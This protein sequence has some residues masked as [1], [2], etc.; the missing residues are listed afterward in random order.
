MTLTFFL[1]T[2]EQID[3]LE[4]IR[5]ALNY[6]DA[7]I[8]L[9]KTLQ[10]VRASLV[11]LKNTIDSNSKLSK[12]SI[13]RELSGD[14]IPYV[15]KFVTEKMDERD[16]QAVIEALEQVPEEKIARVVEFAL[17]LV[18]EEMDGDNVQAVIVASTGIPLENG[19]EVVELAL[20]LIK[21]KMCGYEVQY[22]IYILVQ[23]PQDAR[24]R[25]VECALRLVTEEMTGYDAENIVNALARVPQ[26]E[27]AQIVE[28][29]LELV[30]ARTGARAS[31]ITTIIFTLRKM[32]LSERAEFINIAKQ[33]PN[34]MEAY[35][36]GE[37]VSV[38]ARIPLVKLAQFAQLVWRL[39]REE[40]N[41]RE[42]RSIIV[43]LEKMSQEARAKLTTLESK[44]FAEWMS[45]SDI[46]GIIRIFTRIN[47]MENQE[48]FN[49]AVKLL[50]A[51]HHAC[52]KIEGTKEKQ[53]SYQ[54][55]LIELW[56]IFSTVEHKGR[57]LDQMS[58]LLDKT[59]DVYMHTQ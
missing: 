40:M 21:G 32:S 6:Q 44:L 25:I 41:G 55:K 8:T 7:P 28:W 17:K 46:L 27:I 51:F 35:D 30:C 39:K 18:T 58:L 50:T 45:L 4:T 42:V 1:C 10:Q 14:L 5:N 59:L 2:E 24:A 38:F 47:R 53:E 49:K 37:C 29:G 36:V 23:A 26:G 57:S 56:D 12:F 9:D 15:E 33:M 13:C 16:V 22:I 34:K 54:K 48:I 52:N 20:K 19:A 11:S 3:M 31:A 43:I